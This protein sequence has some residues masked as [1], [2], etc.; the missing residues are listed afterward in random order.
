MTTLSMTDPTNNTTADANVIASNNAAVK[1]V[2]NGNIDNANVNS[3]AAIAVS[4]LAG[5]VV[6]G[7][8]GTTASVLIKCGRTSAN[9]DGA[10]K[11]TTTYSGAFP[12]A[13][14]CVIVT[15]GTASHALTLRTFSQSASTFV[16]E[17]F[18]PSGALDPSAAQVI[19]WIAIG[20]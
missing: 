20:H 16:T 13:T 2:V 6:S 15:A 7:S 12:T 9:S 17:C 1:A 14:D 5:K 10:G 11:V 19:D 3:A 4:K 18:A 8:D